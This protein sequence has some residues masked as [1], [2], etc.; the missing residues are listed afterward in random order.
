[1]PSDSAPDVR[2]LYYYGRDDDQTTA[3]TPRTLDLAPFGETAVTD[4]RYDESSIMVLEGLDAVRKNPG[5]YIGGVGTAGLLHLVH[6]VIDNA[7][8]EALE[9]YCD[10]ILV[11]LHAR[12]R[13]ERTCAD[14][15]TKCCAKFADSEKLSDQVRLVVLL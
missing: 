2:P 14:F 1:M 11:R 8:D 4:K 15:G 6:E 13:P 10:S 5:M 12:A 9:G 3:T 7:V